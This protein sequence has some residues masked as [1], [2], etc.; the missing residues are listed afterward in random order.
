MQR[1]GGPET[2]NRLNRILDGVFGKRM[3]G[4]LEFIAA[5]GADV[6]DQDRLQNDG[7]QPTVAQLDGLLR[8]KILPAHLH[9]QVQGRKLG[10]DFFQITGQFVFG[11]AKWF[12]IFHK[13]L[14]FLTTK[15]TNMSNKF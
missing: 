10:L 5:M 14:L 11:C 2:F 15:Y 1:T 12:L 3:D 8:R 9:Q 13:E 7:P 4:A 6:I